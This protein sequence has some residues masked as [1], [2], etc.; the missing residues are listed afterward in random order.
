MS[1]V[2]SGSGGALGNVKELKQLTMAGAVSDFDVLIKACDLQIAYAMTGQA[3]STNV[4]DTGTQ[5]VGGRYRR[6]PSRPAM[7]TMRGPSPT[8]CSA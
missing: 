6:G 7:R 2:T 1:L 4:S 8:P 5:G 3:L